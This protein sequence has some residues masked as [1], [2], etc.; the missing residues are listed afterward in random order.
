MADNKTQF[1]IEFLSESIEKTKDKLQETNKELDKT[2]DTAQETEQEVKK[3]NDTF[4]DTSQKT[5]KVTKKVKNSKIAF[6][7]FQSQIQSCIV[8][9]VSIGAVMATVRKSL[10]LYDEGLAMDTLAKKTGI[11]REELERLSQ[12]GKT[13]GISTE[14]TATSIE[15][16]QQYYKAR[17]GKS[18][19]ADEAYSAIAQKMQGMTAKQQFEFGASIG[20]DEGTILLLG[21]GVEKYNQQ[22]EMASN[23]K[24]WTDDDLKNLREYRQNM[25]QLHLGVAQIS[26]IIARSLLPIL[27]AIL[28]PINAVFRFLSKH[29]GIVKIVG[30][31]IGLAGA[32][33]L[34]TGALAL[35][36]GA[37][38]AVSVA[39]TAN[40][41]GLIIMAIAAAVT[42]L[43]V[44]LNDL[45]NFIQGNDSVIGTV[46]SKMG[47]DV[48]KLRQNILNFIDSAK[49]GFNE[50][51][52]KIKDVGGWFK[53]LFN[54]IKPLLNNPL[55]GGLLGLG[56]AGL[57]LMNG[58]NKINEVN[59]NPITATGN[60]IASIGE[61][62]KK[63]GLFEKIKENFTNNN[64]SND[65]STSTNSNKA[66]S[67]QNLEIK[68][69]ANAEDIQ[70]VL[71]NLDNGIKI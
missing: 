67:I 20:L 14:T 60:A 45:I 47:V 70:K 50:F 4:D 41:I 32:I 52:K 30:L 69:G 19:T 28:K 51:I 16:A 58:K 36:R 53:W 21:Q 61:E 37:M 33:K 38:T 44:I 26:N 31:F 65:N 22:M 10:Q 24:L 48:D 23:Y 49:N 8:K 11:L 62:E 29:E 5:E 13:F 7:S 40:P 68:T 2:Q 25:G 39:A 64:I 66:I 54:L 18:G 71:L 42:A 35:A 34:V 3:L 17:T 55:I 1:I 59:S 6:K 12:V 46:L 27:N 56:G 57:A 63:K 9:L 15:K 43:I